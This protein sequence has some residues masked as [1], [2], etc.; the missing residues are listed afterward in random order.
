MNSAAIA[1]FTAGSVKR[2][3]SAIPGAR[4]VRM[5]WDPRMLG[6]QARRL[7]AGAFDSAIHLRL[8]VNVV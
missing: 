1:C 8:A 3:N 2:R 7:Q 6:D 4:S 5:A